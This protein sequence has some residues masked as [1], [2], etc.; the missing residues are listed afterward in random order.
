MQSAY[1]FPM[2]TAKKILKVITDNNIDLK[3]LLG[4]WISGK[5][6]IDN[7]SQ[8]DRAIVLT[9]A[10]RNIVQAVSCGMKFSLV[11]S[12]IFMFRI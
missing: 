3:V 5:T 6:P 11:R 7:A 9:N 12:Q 1:I 4:I 2:I 10:Y 8:V